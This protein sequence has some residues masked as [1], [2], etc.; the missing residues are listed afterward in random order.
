MPDSLKGN[1]GGHLHPLR[2]ASADW[3]EAPS[4]YRSVKSRFA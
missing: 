3:V 1:I 2:C 4:V